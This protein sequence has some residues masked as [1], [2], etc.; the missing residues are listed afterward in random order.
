MAFIQKERNNG[1]GDKERSELLYLGNL[2]H[3]LR[4]KNLGHQRNVMFN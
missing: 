2:K 4:V 1:R 3:D